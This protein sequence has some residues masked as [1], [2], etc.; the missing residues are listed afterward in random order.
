MALWGS[1]VLERWGFVGETLTAKSVVVKES[2]E[3]AV[4]DE[5]DSGN[6]GLILLYRNQNDPWRER[7]LY[8]IRNKVLGLI[9]TNGSFSKV[10]VPVDLSPTTLLILMFLRQTYIGKEGIDI[11]FVHVLNGPVGEAEHRWH[12]LTRL[13][14]F[15]TPPLLKLIHSKGDV[16]Q[17]LIE[18]IRIDQFGT[19]IMGK[20]GLSRIKRWLLGSVSSGV[21]RRLTDQSLFLID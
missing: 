1:E 2:H 6:H 7:L 13:V 11:R 17:D 8:K 9:G 15:E 21:L 18:M 5:I 14:D 19:I 20:R 16:A 3:E 4:V 10:L 12:E